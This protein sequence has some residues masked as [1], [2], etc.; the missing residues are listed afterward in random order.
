MGQ[1]GVLG[2]HSPARDLEDTQ[3]RVKQ[4][5]M[6]PAGHGLCL[7]FLSPLETPGGRQ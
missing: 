4:L 1:L 7:Q 3:A 2:T 6:T 5:R